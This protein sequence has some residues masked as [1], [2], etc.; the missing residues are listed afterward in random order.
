MMLIAHVYLVPILR[1]HGT[2]PPPFHILMAQCLIKHRDNF[3][4]CG[5]G[6]GEARS[7]LLS[8]G[9]DVHLH[10]CGQVMCPDTYVLFSKYW[11][12]PLNC[13]YY[14]SLQYMMFHSI[15]FSV[16]FVWCYVDSCICEGWQETTGVKDNGVSFL[17][18]LHHIQLLSCASHAWKDE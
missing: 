15:T 5:L 6:G 4:F 14:T 9:R 16:L 8:K 1:K 18:A 7:S 11:N 12:C 2:L 13:M 17:M 3:T 10:H